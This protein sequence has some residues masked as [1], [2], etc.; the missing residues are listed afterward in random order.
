MPST[1]E[2]VTSINDISEQARDQAL[3]EALEIVRTSGGLRH[4]ERR[5]LDL[6]GPEQPDTE[7]DGE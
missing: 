7:R 2:F 6:L 5:L 1:P 4:A 3:D